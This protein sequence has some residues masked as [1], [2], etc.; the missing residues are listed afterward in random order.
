M[1]KISVV[2]PVY[3]VEKYLDRC[4]QSI[5]NQSLKDI[6][7]ILVDDG[8]PDSCPA[9]CDK[10]AQND[11]RI[12]VVHKKNQGLGFARN[13]GIEVSTGEYITFVDSDDY[14]ARDALEKV[15]SRL[16]ET[17]A[18][19]CIAGLT[20]KKDSGEEIKRE[21]PLG[22]V[23]L[24]KDAILSKVLLGMVGAEPEYK[25]DTYIGMS[26]CKCTYLNK[27]LK[28]NQLRFPSEREYISEDMIFQLRVFPFLNRVCTLSYPY[29]YYC[30]NEAST[31]LTQKYSKDRF[32]RYET[33]YKKELAM[34]ENLGEIEN[35]KYRAA[36]MFLG[37]IRVC[38]KQISGN[39]RISRKEK[40]KL[41]L[42]IANNK[43]FLNVISWY[44]WR[45]N[46]FKQKIMTFLLKH[47][48]VNVIIM[49]S[50]QK[51]KR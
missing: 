47:K 11:S 15:Y 32:Y 46:P 9:L 37:N 50:K 10:Y 35:G 17:K 36:R 40:E 18:D 23:V 6:E 45:K 34:L 48:Q 44:P 19:C 42:E 41:I 22:D 29:Y 21:N 33:L 38:I 26:T 31:S 39:S 8:S 1:Y 2:V 4:V 27:I 28:E 49:L 43:T 12:K 30:H 5:I 25:K 16:K 14:I 3:N 20:D 51:T 7:I 13:S 24:E